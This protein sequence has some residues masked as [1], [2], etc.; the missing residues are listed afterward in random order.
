MHHGSG[1]EEKK[2]AGYFFN[3]FEKT[4]KLHWGHWSVYLIPN[5]LNLRM[6]RVGEEQCDSETWNMTKPADRKWGVYRRVS[7]NLKPIT[8]LGLGLYV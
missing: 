4:H 2:N 1:G 7:V 3:A 6:I 5:Q 8:P